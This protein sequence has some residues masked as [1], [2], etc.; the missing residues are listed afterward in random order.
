MQEAERR[1]KAVESR[2]GG[3][4]SRENREKC[5]CCSLRSQHEG[6]MA[7][8]VK[9]WARTWADGEKVAAGQL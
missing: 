1:A 7:A 6:I 9:P 5:F 2:V 3:T 4:R 8:M